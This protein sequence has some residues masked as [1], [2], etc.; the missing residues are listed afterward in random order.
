MYTFL[1]TLLGP[2]HKTTHHH[3]HAY[4]AT[5]HVDDMAKS[6]SA[7]GSLNSSLKHPKKRKTVVAPFL[8]L[9]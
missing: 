3:P 7:N 8:V 4:G 2:Q 6:S 5:S 1:T 9:F